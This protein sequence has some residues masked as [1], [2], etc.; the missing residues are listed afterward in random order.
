VDDSRGEFQ[1]VQRR[2]EDY[3]EKLHAWSH[4]RGTGVQ[5]WAWA[6]ER[7]R[8]LDNRNPAEMD[9][10]SVWNKSPESWP[11]SP[12]GEPSVN[13]S[14]KI[15]WRVEVVFFVFEVVEST[16]FLHIFISTYVHIN[17]AIFYIYLIWRRWIYARDSSIESILS[18]RSS[19]SS[20]Q[21][22]CKCTGIQVATCTCNSQQNVI[23]DISMNAELTN[24]LI[25]SFPFH[26]F[27]SSIF[28]VPVSK[29]SFR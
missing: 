11:E 10:K 7:A 19:N 16:Y 15:D 27:S 5:T 21:V 12:T 13:R 20:Q 4:E 18:R 1:T 8:S 22:Q 29:V 24:V 23:R 9:R 2:E 26:V 28:S 25:F 6:S 14:L 17:L 3:D